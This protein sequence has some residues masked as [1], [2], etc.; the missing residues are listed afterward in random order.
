MTVKDLKTLIKNASYLDKEDKQQILD[1]FS[2]ITL[3]QAEELAIVILYAE[4]KKQSM[5]FEKDILL[6]SVAGIF[7]E[8]NKNALKL[9][10]KTVLNESKKDQNKKDQKVSDEILKKLENL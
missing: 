3:K 10:K 6:T 9:A 2:K 8:M 4:M 7:T 5:E 1:L